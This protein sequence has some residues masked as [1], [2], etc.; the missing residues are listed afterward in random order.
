MTSG[1]TTKE[2]TLNCTP[3]LSVGLNGV[4]F[5]LGAT[6]LKNPIGFGG[7]FLFGACNVLAEKLIEVVAAKYLNSKNPTVKTIASVAQ[8]FGGIAAAWGVLA[9]TGTHLSLAKLTVLVLISYSLG[10]GL[11]AV[12][13][14]V[15]VAACKILIGKIPE[16]VKPL[17]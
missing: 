13:G 17:A 4:A 12:A 3:V 5:G 1:I 8:F 7:G 15:V 2:L 16:D 11:L 10:I 9:M 6:V 14:I